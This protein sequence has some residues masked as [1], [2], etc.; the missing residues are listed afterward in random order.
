MI[1]IAIVAGLILLNGVFAMSE[2][3]V[4]SSSRPLLRSMAERGHS[5]ATAAIKLAEDP[6]RVM[7][8]IKIGITQIGLVGGAF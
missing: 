1:E 8:T 6:G 4:V 2:L 5:G 3:A 7:S